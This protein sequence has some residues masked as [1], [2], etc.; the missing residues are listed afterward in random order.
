MRVA[1]LVTSLLLAMALP[2]QTQTAAPQPCSDIR[3][4]QMDFWVGDWALTWPGT[5]AGEVAH[6]KNTV[7][8]N[9]GRMCGARKFQR[10]GFQPTA[11]NQRF[12]IRSELRQME[13][14]MGGQP[15]QL[16]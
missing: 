11:R 6:G 8:R 13:A 16:S 2:A 12:N 14:D 15:G 9:Y 4:K 1:I 7:Q 5:K 10:R 3:Q